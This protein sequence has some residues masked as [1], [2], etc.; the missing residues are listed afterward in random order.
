[1]SR[2][3]CEMMIKG[4]GN[5]HCLRKQLMGCLHHSF[6]CGFVPFSTGTLPLRQQW[7]KQLRN[8][9]WEIETKHQEA[10]LPD[11]EINYFLN[12]CEKNKD[13]FLSCIFHSLLVS[14][15]LDSSGFFGD[16][17]IQLYSKCGD[18]TKGYG[19]FCKNT[20]PTLYSWNSIL[21]A[22]VQLEVFD[23]A[24]DLFHRMN[25]L[26][27]EPDKFTFLAVLKASRSLGQVRLLHGYVIEKGLHADVVIG[28]AVVDRYAKFHDMDDAYQVFNS[29][30]ERDVVLWNTVIGGF[31]QSGNHIS[32]SKVSEV[33]MQSGFVPNDITCL[34]LLKAC[35]SLESP[36]IF[37]F[38][39]HDMIIRRGLESITSVANSIIDM[40]AKCGS[41]DIARKLFDSLVCKDSVTWNAMI[42]GYMQNGNGWLA[43]QLFVEMQGST[44]KPDKY[45]YA[46]SLQACD[47]CK[48]F[49]DLQKNGD[50]VSWNS[51]IAGYTARGDSTAAVILF[52]K[53]QRHAVHADDVT[54]SWVL[55]AYTSEEDFEEAYAQTR[56][57]VPGLH[58]FE[59]M[60]VEE[61]TPDNFTFSCVI[62]ICGDIK[63][64]GSGRLIHHQILSD[65]ECDL[66]T[67]NSLVDMYNKFGNMEESYSVF[68]S[69]M[70]TDIIT[71]NTIISG[72]TEQDESFLVLKLFGRMQEE[73]VQP[74]EVTYSHALKACSSIEA[75]M[76]ERWVHDQILRHGLEQ[77]VNIKDHIVDLQLGANTFGDVQNN[78]CIL[79]NGKIVEHTPQ[80]PISHE[81][82]LLAFDW[83][84]NM[85]AEKGEKNSYL[86]VLKTCSNCGAPAQG[87]FV[88]DQIIRSGCDIDM[89][90]G[91][92]LI[93]L[94]ANCGNIREARALFDR[95]PN[96]D[97]VA[98]NAMIA[99]Y[100][101]HGDYLA[102]KYCLEAMR[103]HGLMP[104]VRTYCSV[105]AVCSRSGKSEEGNA[106]LQSMEESFGVSPGC[107][108]FTCMI[109]LLS[110]EGKLDEAETLLKSSPFSPDAPEWRALLSACRAH[111][112]RGL[113]RECYSG[114]VLSKP[115]SSSGYVYTDEAKI[116]NI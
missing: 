94:Y 10:S 82:G 77:C 16:H 101:L 62:K 27:V 72:F 6:D 32:A 84:S 33:M 5:V 95:L 66:G 64:T 3:T 88:H 63:D 116:A 26:D 79:G 60:Q 98:W 51:I 105:L 70:S 58:L 22:H 89:V 91:S 93:N 8:A 53:M 59:R 4:R 19:I 112:D 48:I 57:A 7:V 80:E 50:V 28:S 69:L 31:V 61:I 83:F 87:M 75:G 36:T 114:I 102:A 68:E 76:E 34:C 45:T 47:A 67:G 23:K 44:A 52:E 2:R 14:L 107:R 24:L 11:C 21:N 40:Y 56:R 29:L 39:T 81:N 90:V 42:A 78:L 18:L 73:S 46:S 106:Y 115:E 113:G 30:K 49:G 85:H 12:E 15:G 35:V 96:R 43:L 37:K 71:W 65:C 92:T 20:C 41:L 109:D 55:K 86:D 100:T 54:Y 17:L 25:W 104:D 103:N 110:R 38:L 108:H 74:D 13:L 9:L 99:G 1:M 97:V 111:G